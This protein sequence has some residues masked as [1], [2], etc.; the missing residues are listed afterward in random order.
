M[1]DG[2]L[3]ADAIAL[4]A[5]AYGSAARR[6]TNVVLNDTRFHVWSGA[7]KPYQHHYGKGG[8][9]THTLEVIDLC[10]SNNA[11]F[12]SRKEGV[13][14]E[15]AFLAALFHDVGKMWDYV[16]TNAEMTEWTG[17]DHRR[18]IH[19]ISRSAIV[20]MQAAADMDYPEISAD[21]ILHAILAHHGR[22]EW[23]S[24]VTPATRLAWL[25]HL[26]DALSARMYD[27]YTLEAYHAGKEK[28]VP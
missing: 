10:L 5:E 28:H 4:R 13:P 23:G 20:W 12:T 2:K 27:C 9:A 22:K 19:H 24:P 3:A 25:L 14:D 15:Y 16:P 1:M 17:S 18:Q 7:S 21:T 11:F 6:L 26:C 8:L